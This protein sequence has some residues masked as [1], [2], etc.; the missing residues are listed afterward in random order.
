MM[1]SL[2]VL[3]YLA[4]GAQMANLIDHYYPKTPLVTGVRIFCCFVWLPALVWTA[5][6]LAMYK[7]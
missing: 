1:F 7:A 2:A 6:K 3:A 5:V 4:I